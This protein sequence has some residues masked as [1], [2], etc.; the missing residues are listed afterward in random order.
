MAFHPPQGAAEVVHIQ[1]HPQQVVPLV[2]VRIGLPGGV[3]GFQG[4]GA[5]F[6]IAVHLP[7]Q[8]IEHRAVVV[9]FHVQPAQLVA[10]AGQTLLEQG[11]FLLGH[12]DSVLSIMIC[13]AG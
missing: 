6:G 4:G 9:Q 1:H 7:A 12:R 11:F 10:M 5:G 3:P 13:T 2:P 8:R